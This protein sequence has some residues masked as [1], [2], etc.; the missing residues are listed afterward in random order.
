MER[1]TIRLTYDP[2]A[3]SLLLT[4]CDPDQQAESWV[5]PADGVILDFDA[6]RNPIS[7]EIQDAS[8]RYP[9]SVLLRLSTEE[10]VPLA[11]L[12]E[13]YG[14]AEAHLRRLAVQQRLAAIKIGRNWTATRAALED[15]LEGRRYNAKD[16]R[17]RLVDG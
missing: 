17:T 3:D 9:K 15:Y 8:R 1:E 10:P 13:E 14:F 5:E 2:E 16:V 7:L 6:G 12:A 4:L 11:L